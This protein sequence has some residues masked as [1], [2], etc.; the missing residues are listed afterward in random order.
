V[1]ARAN[2]GRRVLEGV[3]AM[4]NDEKFRAFGQMVFGMMSDVLVLPPGEAFARKTVT[5][6]DGRGG[7]HALELI[8]ARKEVADR[9]EQAAQEAYNVVDVKS[10]GERKQ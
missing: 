6:P 10:P 7:K 3:G 9:M 4:S 2:A 5:M 8:V 1:V